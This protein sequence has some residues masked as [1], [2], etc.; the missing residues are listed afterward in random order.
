MTEASGVEWHARPRNYDRER[1]RSKLHFEPTT[2]SH[3]LR[4][5]TVVMSET[6]LKKSD[7]SKSAAQR[8]TFLDPLSQAFEGKDPLS[9]FA[10]EEERTPSISKSSTASRSTS[11]T[12]EP[13]STKRTRILS[14][15]TTTEKLSIVTVMGTA[16]ADRKETAS[17]T[18]SEKVK[19]RLEQLD[20]LEE[21]SLQEMLNLSQQEYIHRI[22]VR[23]HCCFIGYNICHHWLS[24]SGCF[25]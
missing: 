17:G 19:N 2:D 10:A 12:F 25:D 18:V 24:T 23:S 15:Y 8:P 11:D 13:W 6:S 22:E 20:D 4:E 7:A 5:V 1:R 14:K 21:G 9:V 16:S 3:P